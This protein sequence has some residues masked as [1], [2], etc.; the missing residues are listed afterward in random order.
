[1]TIFSEIKID[2]KLYLAVRF[3]IELNMPLDKETVRKLKAGDEVRINGVIYAARDAA[4]KRMI[5]LLRD[6]KPLPFDIRNQVIYYVGPCPAK[7]GEV[8]G[9]AGPTTSYRM[10]AYAP[11]LIE[12]GLSGMVGK[13]MRND[14]VISAMVKHGAVY[15]GALGGAGALIARSIISEEIIAF[16]DLGTE[17]LRKLQVKDFP[18]IVVIDSYGENLYVSGRQKYINKKMSDS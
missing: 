4:H 18:A 1:L 15:F 10:D 14:E 12:L 8:I 5:E 7:P 13:G 11:K 6:G 2:G 3:L 9:S 16:P 17:A